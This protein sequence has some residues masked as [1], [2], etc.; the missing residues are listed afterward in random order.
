MTDAASTPNALNLYV[1][2]AGKRTSAPPH[3]D[4]QDVVV[5]QSSGELTDSRRQ[6][7]LGRFFL[8]MLEM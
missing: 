1:T 7:I 4:K 5:V 8:R 6:N 3:T 2:A